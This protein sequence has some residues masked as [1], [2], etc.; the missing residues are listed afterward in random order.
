MKSKKE[1][2]NYSNNPGYSGF[3]QASTLS[4]MGIGE[5]ILRG[6]IF[7]TPKPATLEDLEYTLPT[8]LIEWPLKR[9][10]K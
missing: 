4:H 5:E 1:S 8:K 7:T 2:S 9:D 3:V 6:R 10:V